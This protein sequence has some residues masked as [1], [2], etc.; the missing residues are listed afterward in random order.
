MY[1]Y[2]YVCVCVCVFVCMGYSM[3]YQEIPFVICTCMWCVAT[4]QFCYGRHVKILVSYLCLNV[5]NNM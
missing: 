3:E 1:I 5:C 4:C 2:I